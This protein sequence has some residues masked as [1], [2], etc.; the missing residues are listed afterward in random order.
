MHCPVCGAAAKLVESRVVYGKDYGWMWVCSSYPDCDTY[1]GCH[2]GTEKPLGRMAGY[3]TREARKKLHS[4]F[5]PLWK[6]GNLTRKECYRRL[7]EA[8]QI[9]IKV[10]HI[11]MFDLRQCLQAISVV[12]QIKHPSVEV[13]GRDYVPSTDTSKAPF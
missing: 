6:N 8:M 11:G 10:C 3:E 7:A 12:T 5:D 9:D 13:V 4:M 1:C 2:K